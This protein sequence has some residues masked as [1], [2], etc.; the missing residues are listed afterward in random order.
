MAP[1]ARAGCSIRGGPGG[2]QPPGS[3]RGSGGRQHPRQ[4]QETRRSAATRL[5]LPF[6]PRLKDCQLQAL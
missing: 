1:P 4:A 6:L 2:R 3:S 5:L